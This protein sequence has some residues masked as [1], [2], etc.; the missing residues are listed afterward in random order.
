MTPSFSDAVFTACYLLTLL[1]AGIVVF[2]GHIVRS[3]FALLLTFFGVAGI[4]VFLH[5][6]FLAGTQVLVYVGGI[7]VLLLFAV[8]LTNRIKDIRIS[9]ESRGKVPA[10]LLSLSVFAALSISALSVPW[11][12]RAL[13][14]LPTTAPLG[15]GLLTDYLLPFEA[16][17]VLLL[18]V[19]VGAAVI[20]RRDWKA[21]A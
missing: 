8:M 10:A 3:A 11:P 2:S 5:A 19:M 21:D 4:Y 16:I 12:R 1:S 9:N 15:L 14:D 7:L 6:D 18:V 20:A 13:P 17:S